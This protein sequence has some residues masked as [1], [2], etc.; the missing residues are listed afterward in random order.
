M[1][2]VHE[3]KEIKHFICNKTNHALVSPVS[4]SLLLLYWFPC[5]LAKN[6]KFLHDYL[7]S[8]YVIF[9]ATF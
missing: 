3:Q 4:L 7:K 5:M 6:L 2:P 8:V 1:T 9:W